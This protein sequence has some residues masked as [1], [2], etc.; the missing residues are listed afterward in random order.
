MITCG[1]NF[2]FTVL[3]EGALAHSHEGNHVLA[4]IKEI[5]SYESLRTTLQDIR[6]EVQ[7]LNSIEVEGEKYAITYYLG[8]DWKFLALVTGIDCAK[9]TQHVFGVSA[10]WTSMET[11]KGVMYQKGQE[12]QR[13]TFQ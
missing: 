7:S 3:N 12:Q 8:G 4:I 5:E 1:I 6:S 11:L 2:T 13:R 9:S 10:V